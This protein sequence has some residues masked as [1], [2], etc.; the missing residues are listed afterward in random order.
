MKW[1]SNLKLSL[2]IC[3]LSFIFIIFIII[4]GIMGLS[5]MKSS[6]IRFKSLNDDRLMPM[7]DLGEARVQLMD[8]RLNVRYHI[9]STDSTSRKHYEDR[10]QENEIIML[11]LL[12]KYS[13]TYLVEEEVTGLEELRE[14]YT[15]YKEAKDKT[16]KLSNENKI[17]E[18]MINADGDAS[19]KYEEVVTAF[20]HLLTIQMNVA[21]EL[22][23]ENQSIYT[24][25]LYMSIGILF[26]CILVG[27]YFTYRIAHAVTLPVKKVT[28]KLKEISENGGDLTQ[29][30]GIDT[31]DEVGELSKAFDLFMDKL[32]SIIKEVISS[33]QIIA[34]SSQQLSTATNETNIAMEQ[35]SHTVTGFADGTS[36]NMAVV[37]QT[38]ASLVE[39][40]RFSETTANASRKTSEN[41]VKVKEA[42]KESASKITGIVDAMNRIAKSSKEVALTIND[43]GDSSQKISEIVMMITGI[44]EQTNLLALNASIESARAGEAGKG[45]SVVADEIRKLADSSNRLAKDI[46]SLVMDNQS[47]V[48]KTQKSV[49][50]VNDM[51]IAGEETAIEVKHNMDHIISNIRDIVE[52]ITDIDKAVEKQAEI[53]DEITK[54]MNNI[55]DNATDMTAA[56]E[57]MSANLEEQVSTLEE[58]EATVHQLAEMAQQLHNITSGFKA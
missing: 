46:A 23:Q 21:H 25:M 55:A 11:A 4:V 6:N 37:Q 22:Y 30:I 14:K 33:A 58:I 57:E 15:I 41:S 39:A 27:L 20:N 8:I 43:L 36:E 7:Y 50:I 10:I 34:T 48:L 13:V 18:A 35:I 17:N 42:A 19:Q 1:F 52:Q 56:T 26:F 40:A 38:T 49:K 16:I 5:N 12:D 29:R 32:Q 9:N 51:V 2:K 3:M 54:G 47:N 24:R 44:S 45:F 28:N 53:T 31:K